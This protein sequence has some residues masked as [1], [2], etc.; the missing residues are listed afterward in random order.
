MDGGQPDIACGHELCQATLRSTTSLSRIFLSNLPVPRHLASFPIF[1]MDQVPS[2]P[3]LQIH[4]DRPQ[5]Y[6]Q[7]SLFILDI[8]QIYIGNHYS[9]FSL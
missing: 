3:S 2:P 7:K 1:H 6:N 9:A 4:E 5:H 8:T